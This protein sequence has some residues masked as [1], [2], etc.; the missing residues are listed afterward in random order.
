[1][2]VALVGMCFEW[3]CCTNAVR[4]AGGEEEGKKENVGEGDGELGRGREGKVMGVPSIAS[5]PIK[6]TNYY[7]GG[8]KA[9]YPFSK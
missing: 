3:L 6:D 9:T 8:E 5:F 2:W 4:E 7:S 1:M